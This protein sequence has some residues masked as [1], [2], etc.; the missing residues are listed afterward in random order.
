MTET[1]PNP[2]T[3]HNPDEAKTLAIR[4]KIIGIYNT[5]V[6]DDEVRSEF[7]PEQLARMISY[8]RQAKDRLYDKAH[9]DYYTYHINALLGDPR[10][11]REALDRLVAAGLAVDSPKS[12]TDHLKESYLQKIIQDYLDGADLK[13]KYP[14]AF[15]VIV[16]FYGWRFPYAVDKVRAAQYERADAKVGQ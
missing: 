5:L 15:I 16:K 8:I 3:F 12:F 2:A 6:T 4:K 13:A 1:A 14:D 10:Y 7:D 9:I 11:G